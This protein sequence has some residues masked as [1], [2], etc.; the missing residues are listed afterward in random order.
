MAGSFSGR[1]GAY[2][3]DMGLLN[4]QMAEILGTSAQTIGSYRK[5][6]SAPTLE[7][8]PE[9]AMKLGVTTD[10][11][12][13]ATVHRKWGTEIAEARL[14][15]RSHLREVT[16]ADVQDRMV[17]VIG[18]MRQVSPLCQQDWFMAGILGLQKDGKCDSYEA[19][20]QG[21]VDE[22]PEDTLFR[23]AEFVDLP[24]L[25][26]QLGGDKYLDGPRDIGDYLPGVLKLIDEGVTGAEFTRHAPTLVSVALRSR[27]HEQ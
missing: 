17:K 20:M 19:F 12:L 10:W 5:G 16:A 3:D 11:L 24:T 14:H 1:F 27:R 6:K 13:G 22:F 26:L 18:L 15:V 25:W 7:H 4:K 23:F 8:L 21:P 2:L 9:V